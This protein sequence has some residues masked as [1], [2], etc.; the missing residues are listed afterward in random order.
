M[1]PTFEL[2][3]WLLKK[4]PQLLRFAICNAS[5]RSVLRWRIAPRQSYGRMHCL[6]TILKY[7]CVFGMRRE[8]DLLE[9]L[10]KCSQIVNSL[11]NLDGNKQ[12]LIGSNE[13]FLHMV[14]V[15]CVVHVVVDVLSS[16][17]VRPAADD[18]RRLA[19]TRQ[20]H[21]RTRLHHRWRRREQRCT[22]GASTR[23]R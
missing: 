10:K 17:T 2:S 3:E 18:S 7:S 6:V 14:K 9:L 20:S 13:H 19:K 23:T 22:S 11:T 8:Q 4:P 12:L 1:L 15:G 21:H 5:K 16:L